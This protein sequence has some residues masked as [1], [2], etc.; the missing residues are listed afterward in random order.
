MQPQMTA[1]VCALSDKEEVRAVLGRVSCT[2]L[3]RGA[4]AS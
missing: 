3:M 1:T 2:T 4:A